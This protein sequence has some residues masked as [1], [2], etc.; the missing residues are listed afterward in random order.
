MASGCSTINFFDE[1]IVKLDN[2]YFSCLRNRGVPFLYTH[3]SDLNDKEEKNMKKKIISFFMLISFTAILFAETDVDD[4]PFHGWKQAETEHFRFIFEDASRAQ[5]EIYAQYADDAWNKIAKIYAIPQDKTDVYVTARTNT[6]NAFTFF[7]PPEIMMFTTPL[8]IP[9]FGFRDNWQKLFFTHELVHIANVQFEDKKY[10]ASKLFGQYVRAFDM[11]NMPGWAL[12]GLTTVMETELTDGGRGRSPYFE[13]LYKAPTLDNAFMSYTDVGTEQEPPRGQA[14]VMGYLIMKSIADRWGLDALADI[15]RNRSANVSWE[16]SVLLVTGESAADIYKDVRIALA[17]KYAAERSIPEGIII[18]P[19][20]VNTY[21]YKPALVND[22]GTLITLRSASHTETA[23]VKLD[24]SAK[25][26]R[27]FIEDEAPEKDLNTV[28]S[29]SVLFTGDFSDTMAVTA[30]SDGTVYASL[31]KQRS[32]RMPG[33]EVAYPLYKWTKKTG[34]VQ[35]TK[36]GSFFEPSVSRNGA[37]LVAVEQ[38]GLKMRLVRVDTVTGD[39]TELLQSNECSFIQPAVNADGSKVAFL[40]LDD[41]RA[42]VAFAAVASNAVADDAEHETRATLSYTIVANGAGAIVDP[43]Y[44]SWNSDGKLTYTC[45]T[46]GRLEVFEVTDEPVAS[47]SQD[48]AVKYGRYSSRPVVADPIG[49]LWAYK[50]ERGVYY[51]S[52]ASSGYVIKMKPTEEWGD[53][54]EENGPSAPGEK[55]CFG[56]LETD[57]PFF[58]PYEKPSEKVIVEKSESKKTESKKKEV[59]VAIRGKKVARRSEENEKRAESFT[60]VQTTLQHEKLFVPLPKPILYIPL[61]TMTTCGSNNDNYLFGVGYGVMLMAPKLQ[62]NVGVAALSASYYPECDN[63]TGEAATAIPVGSSEIDFLASRTLTNEKTPEEA[64]LF[65]ERNSALVGITVPFV[66]RIQHA[67]EIDVSMILFAN[68]EALRRSENLIAA[69]DDLSYTIDSNCFAG[70]DFSNSKQCKKDNVLT[71]NVTA[72]GVGYFMPFGQKAYAGFEGESEVIYGSTSYKTEVSL[73]GRYTD[74]PAETK[75]AQSRA[76]LSDET[77]DCTYPGRL[78]A[79]AGTLVPNM[80]GPGVNFELFAEKLFSFGKNTVDYET[81]ESGLPCNIQFDTTMV[82]GAELNISEG[83]A[84]L[85][86]GYTLRFDYTSLNLTYGKL[87][88][89]AKW[90]WLRH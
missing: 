11:N 26:G 23:V 1:E 16:D 39:V 71:F 77:T 73:R 64:Y 15:E 44:P 52:Y 67:N 84:K 40:V 63:F 31:A 59:P 47:T 78:V 46:R 13:L 8:S 29:E 58:V 82:T 42:A 62:M 12:E 21:Y 14:Y 76:H 75:P 18:S 81:P 33:S 49:A 74:Y 86:A 56:T 30:S 87:Y 24:P 27:N 36:K 10:V 54:P 72:L 70:L 38:D 28:L 68:I 53:V 51:E 17:K 19:R 22:D 85:A 89:S 32:D 83:R 41:H 65:Q 88:V 50:T 60:T 4:K 7:V 5:T 34:L 57:Y 69:S 6:V 25:T 66:H 37:V 3:K 9:D 43:A 35:L 2:G 20:D 90:N 45:N 48:T 55:I 80:L 61:A 79:R